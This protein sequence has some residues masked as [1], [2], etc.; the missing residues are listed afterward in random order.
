MA[1]FAFLIAIFA[2]VFSLA[3]LHLTIIPFYRHVASRRFSFDSNEDA[4]RALERARVKGPFKFNGLEYYGYVEPELMPTPP[5]PSDSKSEPEREPSPNVEAAEGSEL[6]RFTDMNIYYNTID[7][8][9]EDCDCM[10]CLQCRRHDGDYTA[11]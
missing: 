5:R 2:A 9:S 10:V 1:S 6:L 4:E 3:C 7:Y 8:P 11:A